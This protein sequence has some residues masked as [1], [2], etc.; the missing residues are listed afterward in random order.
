MVNVCTTDDFSESVDALAYS[1]ASGVG[2]MN[3]AYPN[4]FFTTAILMGF[5]LM[6]SFL[7]LSGGSNPWVADVE[8]GKI[9]DCYLPPEY[10]P[11]TSLQWCVICKL[12]TT[13]RR[14]MCRNMCVQT[15]VGFTLYVPTRC[16]E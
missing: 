2:E 3:I 10:L 6:C 15:L 16:S 1:I 14:R 11:V 4:L 5:Q 9:C 8:F 12:L 13:S 7:A